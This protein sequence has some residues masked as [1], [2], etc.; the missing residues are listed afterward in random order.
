MSVAAS[1]GHRPSKAARGT[2]EHNARPDPGTWSSE[3]GD[4]EALELP[5]G[6]PSAGRVRH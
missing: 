4:W 6:G 1:S 2:P 5:D 3:E